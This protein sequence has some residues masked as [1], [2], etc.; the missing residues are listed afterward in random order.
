MNTESATL[1]PSGGEF[2]AEQ[3]EPLSH[4]DQSVTQV[5]KV[6]AGRPQPVVANLEF[7]RVRSERNRDRGMGRPGV[8]DR[9]GQGLL[10]NP[11]SDEIELVAE[12]T[13]LANHDKLRRQTGNAGLINQ[14]VKPIKARLS[15]SGQCDVTAA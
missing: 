8:L 15:R 12:S 9:V 7:E 2:P 11:E 13:R 6:S 10:N 14:V 5:V 4:P 1:S 3:F